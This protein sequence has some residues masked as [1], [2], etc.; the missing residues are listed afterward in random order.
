MHSLHLHSYSL[1][2]CRQLTS[3]LSKNVKPNSRAFCSVKLPQ[4]LDPANDEQFRAAFLHPKKKNLSV[5][6]LTLRK[7][8][9]D[10][11][12]SGYI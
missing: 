9:T 2:F 11:Q 5:E 10:G 12:V 6:P 3:L 1:K 7:K 8:I 4:D